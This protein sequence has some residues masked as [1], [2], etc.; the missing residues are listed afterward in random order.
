MSAMDEVTV[1]ANPD[2]VPGSESSVESSPVAA[3]PAAAAGADDV[4]AVPAPFNRAES[5]ALLKQGLR[6]EKHARLKTSSKQS[7]PSGASAYA[8]VYFQTYVQMRLQC[9]AICRLCMEQ[10]QFD[11]AEVK[12]NQSPPDLLT[13][14]NT[15][16]SGHQDA[17]EDCKKKKG[18]KKSDS[19]AGGSASGSTLTGQAAIGK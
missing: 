9:Y 6:D 14:L 13:H 7:K 11:R 17:Y 2:G 12:Y 8:W 19:G 3:A 4:E 15:Q 18:G 10:Q 16:N 5:A 1:S